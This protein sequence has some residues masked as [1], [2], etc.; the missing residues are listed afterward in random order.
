LNGSE[1]QGRQYNEGQTVRDVGKNVGAQKSGDE[2]KNAVNR[3]AQ[4]KQVNEVH[5][6]SLSQVFR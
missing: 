4:Q 3:K 6:C 5:G 2:K 1:K